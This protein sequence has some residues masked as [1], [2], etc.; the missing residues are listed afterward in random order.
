M[1]QNRDG[2]GPGGCVCSAS[3]YLLISEADHI[4]LHFYP[5]TYFG[6]IMALKSP[7]FLS[8]FLQED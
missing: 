6:V 3:F 2:L 4:W 8:S 5:V 7:T 1:R